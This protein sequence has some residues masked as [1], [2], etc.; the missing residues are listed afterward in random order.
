MCVGRSFSEARSRKFSSV[1]KPLAIAFENEALLVSL[2]RRMKGE[3]PAASEEYFPCRN[4]LR[5]GSNTVEVFV[6]L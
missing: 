5:K 2:P 6:V 3:R 4:A 1:E